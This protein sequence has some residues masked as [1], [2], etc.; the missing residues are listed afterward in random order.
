MRGVTGVTSTVR[1]PSAIAFRPLR[2][3]V[4]SFSCRICSRS[5]I[6]T[7]VRRIVRATTKAI[8]APTAIAISRSVI[9]RLRLEE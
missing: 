9:V 2:S 1:S 5:R 4:A 3:S 6:V 8:P 7:T